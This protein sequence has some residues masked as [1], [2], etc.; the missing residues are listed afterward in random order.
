MRI[1]ETGKP[2]RMLMT[3][4]DVI[5]YFPMAFKEWLRKKV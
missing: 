5:L 2:Q 3:W 1:N 4:M